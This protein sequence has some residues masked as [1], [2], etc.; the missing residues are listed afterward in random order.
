VWKNY[1]GIFFLS[2][3]T[4]YLGINGQWQNYGGGITSW[5]NP[6]DDQQVVNHSHD[7]HQPA[8]HQHFTTTTPIVSA[9][10]AMR[11]ERTSLWPFFLI[12]QAE[13]K[14]QKLVRVFS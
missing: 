12:Q 10:S 3:E 4:C 6:V 9:L 1:Q 7:L 14:Q 8:T 11:L 2:C 5:R 13:D